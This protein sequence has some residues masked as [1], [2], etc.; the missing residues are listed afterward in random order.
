MTAMVACL[1]LRNMLMIILILSYLLLVMLII[2]DS[3]VFFNSI[4]DSIWTHCP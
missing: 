2:V 1:T 3:S 4:S